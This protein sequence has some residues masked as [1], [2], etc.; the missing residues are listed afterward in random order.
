MSDILMTLPDVVAFVLGRAGETDLE[1]VMNAVNSRREILREIAA[2]AV[3]VGA[4][5][6]LADLSPAYLNGLPGTVKD[7]ATRGNKRIATVTLTAQTAS[8]LGDAGS[9]FA[10]LAGTDRPYDLRVPA[11]CCRVTAG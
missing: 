5:V 3:T 2:A 9:R 11:S 4:P 8:K 7:I 6:T 1:G 10:H